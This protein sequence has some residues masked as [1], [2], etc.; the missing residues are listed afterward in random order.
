MIAKKF[1]STGAITL[2]TTPENGKCVIQSDKDMN[3]KYL[4]LL[5]GFTKNKV[6]RRNTKVESE[7]IANIN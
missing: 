4:G 3:L 6:I 5:L 1:K 2:T 7:N